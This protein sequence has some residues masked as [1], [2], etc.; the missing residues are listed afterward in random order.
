[1]VVYACSDLIFGTKIRSTAD[2]LKVVSRPARDAAM[3]RNRLDQ[4]DD[5]KS[6]EAVHLVLVD[7]D[8]NETA[9][10]LITASKAHSPTIPVIAFGSH[11]ATDVLQSAR[12]AGADHVMPRS[13]FT[14]ML[15]TLL[16]PS[17]A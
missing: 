13:Q 3:L 10:E 9:I 1:M 7:L 2:A 11:V 8:M 14:A 12:D 17:G 15:P 16:A 5:G 6:N 4:V